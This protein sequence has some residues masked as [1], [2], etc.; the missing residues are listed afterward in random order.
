MYLYFY[1]EQD[2][3][4]LD[5]SPRQKPTEKKPP[6]MKYSLITFVYIDGD[7]KDILKTQNTVNI[8]RY[9]STR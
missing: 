4:P 2:K 1:R 6:I 3:S 5:I 9:I 8:K 7:S